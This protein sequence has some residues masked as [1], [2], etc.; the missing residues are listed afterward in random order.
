MTSLGEYQFMDSVM[1]N[2]TIKAILASHLKA[3]AV[4]VSYSYLLSLVGGISC[5]LGSRR[6]RLNYRGKSRE[7]LAAGCL[8]EYGID[9]EY[10]TEKAK[11]TPYAVAVDKDLIGPAFRVYL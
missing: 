9:G 6:R 7:Q 2:F 4:E 8:V 5:I 1:T 11:T 3:E 10:E